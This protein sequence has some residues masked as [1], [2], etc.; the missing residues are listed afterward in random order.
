MTRAPRL[1]PS[2][3]AAAIIAVTL[4]GPPV[5]PSSAAGATLA[6]SERNAVQRIEA[7]LNSVRTV[8]GKFVQTTS[9]G[10]FA[11]GMLYLSRPGNLKI[12]YAPPMSLKVYAD[13]TWLIYV[14]EELKDISQLPIGATPAQFLLRDRIRLSGDVEVTALERRN[15]A[16]RV[17]L[18]QT[19]DAEAG[20]L[21]LNFAAEPLALRGWT[22]VDSRGVEITVSL[23]KPAINQPI[24]KSVFVFSPPD[25]AY[26][27]NE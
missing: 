15:D 11:E 9:N 4:S 18:Q 25:W 27:Q 8:S 26:P 21:I 22:V 12:T 14:D 24:D 7:Y 20:R 6:A 2:L 17:H 16:V 3:L 13:D 5:L 23:F 10:G 19:D 1:L